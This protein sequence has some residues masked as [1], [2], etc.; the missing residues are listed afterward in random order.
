MDSTSTSLVGSE[1]PV[2][3]VQLDLSLLAICTM[4]RTY[5]VIRLYF[6]IFV[7]YKI[8]LLST[9]FLILLLVLKQ[10]LLP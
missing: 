4:T 6:S 10:F 7:P 8:S 2:Q 1:M 9:A 3:D 5:E